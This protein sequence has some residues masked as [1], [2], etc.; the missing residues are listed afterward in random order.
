MFTSK[1]FSNP[2]AFRDISDLEA[3]NKEIY[4]LCL[5]THALRAAESDRL[6]KSASVTDAN[7]KKG[8]TG[9]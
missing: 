6:D 1:C 2:G 4:V 7:T 5:R 3:E 9:R 8:E